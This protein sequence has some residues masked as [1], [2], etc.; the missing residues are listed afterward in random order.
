MDGFLDIRTLSFI[1]V[2]FCYIFGF[3]LIVFHK[4]LKQFNQICFKGITAIGIGQI[5]LGSGFLLISLRNFINEFLS[6][7]I[8]NTFVFGGMV[9]ITEGVFLFRQYRGKLRSAGPVLLS[10]L[11]L[12]FIHYT[13]LQPDIN[14]RITIIS[15]FSSVQFAIC[16][17]ALFRD[18]QSLPEIPRLMTGISMAIA[19][20]F[21]A[22]R[23]AWSLGENP[24]QDFMTAGTIH[25]CAFIVLELIV[26]VLS[27]GVVWM[28]SSTL[29]NELEN[30]AR[31]DPLTEVFNRRGL[32]EAIPVIAAQNCR[33]LTPLSAILVDIDYFKKIN[34]TYGHQ[35]GD[36]ILNQFATLLKQHLRVND[37]F[38]RYGG[39]EFV[40]ILSNTGSD[41][42]LHI[43]ENLRQLIQ[44][45]RFQIFGHRIYVTASFGVATIQ[46]LV[47]RSHWK[48][49]IAW[50]DKALYQAK[51]HGRNQVRYC[52]IPELNR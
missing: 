22:F 45:H 24:L 40:V 1:T 15:L 36:L 38:A 9:L 46:H 48:K 44:D 14:A 8:A 37:I 21:F 42:A 10:I 6:I 12:L 17:S 7:V 50:A 3:S 33:D 43:A 52:I 32:E 30:L 23:A 39:E 16:A 25:S 2:L 27:F 26:I 28:V 18:G 51:Q 34:D 5:F 4:T 19:A 49:I 47:H 13:Y 29:Q 11:F 41:T 20:L 31:V 35:T